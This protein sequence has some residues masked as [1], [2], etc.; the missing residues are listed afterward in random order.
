MD[1]FGDVRVTEH[2]EGDD[3]LSAGL[4]LRALAGAPAKFVNPAAPTTS[5]LRRRA[6]QS[7]WRG[8]ADL[9][10][11]GG[12][13]TVYGDVPDV[14]GREFTT[15]AW[16]PGARQPHRVLAQVPDTF[17][18]TKR[19]LVVTASSGSR[20]IYGSIA[21]AGAWGLS[22]GCAVAYTDKGTGA[23][24]FDTAD[25]TGVALD[26]SRAKVGD[27]LLEFGPRGVRA[28][29][30]IATKHAHSGDN[31]EADWGRHVLQAARFGL[32]M[33]D[34]AFPDEAPFTAQNTRIIATGISN[35]GGAVLRAAGDDVDG[36]LDAVVALEPNIH[37]EGHGRPFFDYATEAALLL[38]AALAAPEFDG[39]PFAR[40]GIAAP[41]AWVLRGA[42]LRAHGKLSGN[43]PQAQAAEALAMLRAGGWR[44]E[45]LKVAASSTSLDL[46]RTVSVA[47]ASAYLR[48]EAGHMP[49]GFS[50]R[51]QHPAGVP[52]PVDA[53]L[54]AAW[55]ADGSGVP[56]HA[57]IA[58]EGGIDLS[59]DPT[60]PGCLSLRDL[61]TQGDNDE[62]TDNARLREGIAA[63]AAALPR[64]GLPVF[65]VHGAEDG[66][67][68]AAFSSEPYV[69][70][71][72]ASGRSPVFWKVPHAQHFD[73][74]LAFP[75][76]G[77]RHVPLL[78]FG[79]AALDRAWAHIASGRPLPEDAL[80]RD[81]QPRGPGALTAKTLALPP[82]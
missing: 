62:G 6:I 39:V 4:G 74:F 56:P 36:I 30:G 76:F 75:D 3:L 61:W 15:F 70:W 81:T 14:P 11:R 44:D 66:L 17:D 7:S 47:Y 48:R 41:P 55:W 16:L 34:R 8:I 54:R 67:I 22:R 42:S 31:P 35:G 33:L 13:G 20:G 43:T 60:L 50:Y 63:T 1:T 77:D 40:V 9:G 72:R 5:E 69:A 45:A 58:L 46:W 24:Y 52:A 19:C 23:G 18:R 78:P 2:R 64:E 38:P 68:P 27:A 37:V 12:Y 49:C 59:L 25:G 21:L 51:I 79:Y 26:G 65:V 53:V 80:V 10:P 32:A 71:L 29:A 73:A 57:G 28:D 82:G